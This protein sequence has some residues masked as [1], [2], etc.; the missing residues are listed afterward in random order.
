MAMSWLRGYVLLIVGLVLPLAYTGKSQPSDGKEKPSEKPPALDRY[1]DPLPQG[2]VARLGTLRWRHGSFV[3]AVTFAPDGKTLASIGGDNV[4]RLSETATGK[5]LRRFALW[6]AVAHRLAFSPDGTSLVADV[7]DSRGLRLLDVQTGK[8][9]GPS[10]PDSA[11]VSSLTFSPDGKTL[12][13]A[14]GETN[15]WL[16]EAATRKRVRNVR[17]YQGP[18]RAVAFSPDGK[19][20]ATGDAG[21]VRLWDA[22]TGE[23]IRKM[24]RHQGSVTTFAFSPDGKVLASGADEDATIRLWEVATGRPLR[25]F[26]H[27]HTALRDAGNSGIHEFDL[28]TTC[29]VFAP[30]GKT[31]YSA[32]R[33]DRF[34]RQWDAATGRELRQFEGHL[35]GITSLALSRDGKILAAGSEDNTARLWETATGNPLGP[36][37]EHRSR[38]YYVAFSS[39]GNRL[40][41]AS[42]D[43]TVRVWDLA[44]QQ[45]LRQLGNVED[46]PFRVAVSPDGKTLATGRGDDETIVLW[47]LTTGK[48]LHRLTRQQVGVSA[49]AFSGDGKILVS[50]AAD[51]STSLWDVARGQFLR[52]FGRRP[53]NG[54][55]LGSVAFSPDGKLVV[56]L[57]GSNTVLALWDA[58]T[59]DLVRKIPAQGEQGAQIFRVLFSPDS[60][61]LA[62][63]T[64]NNSIALWSVATGRRLHLFEKQG[65][66]TPEGIQIWE[67]LA[68]SADGRILAT[69]GQN[70]VIH[71]WEVATGQEVSRFQGH[72]GWLASLAFAPDGRTLASGSLDTTVLLW[73]ASGLGLQGRA[74]A[75]AIAPHDLPT[76]WADLSDAVA[77]KAHRA[78]WS[79]VAAPKQAVP[80]LQEQLRPASVPDPAR[81]T[82][83][84]GDLDSQRFAVR[85]KASREL[86][87]LAELAEPMLRKT[88]NGKPSLEVR[89]RIEQLLDKQEEKALSGNRLRDLRALMVLER[90]GTLE[91]RKLVETLAKGAPQA[92]LTQEAQASLERLAK[93]PPAVP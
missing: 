30:D 35:S 92:Q 87:D 10:I 40:V 82:Q 4:I 48:E 57:T 69:I 5:E 37:E 86:E 21:T 2:A 93:R 22:A 78:L 72:E 66:V 24:R 11:G 89:R 49:L 85:Q 56:S 15:V 80:F 68:F 53:Q 44:T 25:Q 51:H 33:W 28:A 19:L 59:G 60:K 42:R 67:S 38:I 17:A 50:L 23:P 70:H 55:E 84:L 12:A 73:D 14:D 8:S 75:Y 16:W 26:S 46:R 61:T 32:G 13:A 36:Q 41:S 34:I 65:A 29:A 74:T 52:E 18:V 64:L 43:G 58:A 45:Q 1:G 27:R 39:A 79:L 31:V 3:S 20:L 9:F 71:L 88:L 7:A 91:A 54:N 81:M 83:L 63:V 47:D 62:T 77:S 76:L 6:P 90:I